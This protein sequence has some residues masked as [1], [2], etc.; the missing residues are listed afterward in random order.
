MSCT[1]CVFNKN[2]YNEKV[3]YPK[4]ITLAKRHLRFY[5]CQK[6]HGPYMFDKIS[7]VFTFNL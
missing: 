5:R 4:P 3:L 6:T 2:K 1:S 7:N